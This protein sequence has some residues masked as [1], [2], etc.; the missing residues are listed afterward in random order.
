MPRS[1]PSF[2]I[3]GTV[4]SQLVFL[5]TRAGLSF[6]ID[7]SAWLS[8]GDPAPHVWTVQERIFE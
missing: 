3:E 1:L 7:A 2:V 6:A 4:I 8:R 5:T